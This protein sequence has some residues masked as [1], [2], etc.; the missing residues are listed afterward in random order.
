MN[1]RRTLISSLATAGLLLGMGGGIATA[2][3]TD[4]V[5]VNYGCAATTPTV[6]VDFT[7]N[8]DVA[9]FASSGSAADSVTITLDLT[10]NFA[11]NFSVN[12]TIGDFE[13]Q[14]P[15]NG[16]PLLDEDFGGE[17]FLMSGGGITSINFPIIPFVTAAPDIQTNVFQGGVVVD[18]GVIEDENIFFW[19]WL[20]SPGITVATWDS[21]VGALPLN[22]VPGPYTAPLTV[23]LV[24]S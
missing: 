11:T 6:E 15:A 12:A 18:N 10:C 2:A 23:T 9:L 20:A 19:P 22:L 21:S 7:G 1:L 5:L 13:Y 14:G 3:D 17:H 4:D 24:V 16:N 8:I